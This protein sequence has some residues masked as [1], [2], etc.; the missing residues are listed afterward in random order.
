VEW[1]I[2]IFTKDCIT[3]SRLRSAICRVPT[4]LLTTTPPSFH[5]TGG[6][7]SRKNP[8]LADFERKENEVNANVVC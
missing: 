4:E 8:L 5:G 2:S 6:Q 3:F 7:Y 1:C